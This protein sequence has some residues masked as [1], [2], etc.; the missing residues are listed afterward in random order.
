MSI[1]LFT[2]RACRRIMDAAF[3]YAKKHGY[4][5]VTVCDKPNV[6]RETGGL[7]IRTAREVAQ[8]YAGIELWET[9][10]D[11]MCINTAF[12]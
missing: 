1:R 4:K 9:N 5:N 12:F 6:L 3:R 8:N 10:I 7:M 2:R 11:A